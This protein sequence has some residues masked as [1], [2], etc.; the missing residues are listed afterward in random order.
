MDRPVV[1]VVRSVTKPRAMETPA[2]MSSPSPAL[3][4]AEVAVVPVWVAMAENAPPTKSLSPA[5]SGVPT[6]AVVVLFTTEMATVG[7]IRRRAA[8][9]AGVCVSADRVG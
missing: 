5:A 8:G 2:E 6:S 7:A 4:P 3:A 1:A 9:R